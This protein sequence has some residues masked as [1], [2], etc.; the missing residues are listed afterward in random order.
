MLVRGADGRYAYRA[1]RDVARGEE[2]TWDYSATVTDYFLMPCLGCGPGCRGFACR[3]SFMREDERRRIEARHP[4]EW[5]LPHMAAELDAPFSAEGV[6]AR[7]L[8][9]GWDG[10]GSYFDF[11]ADNPRLDP[12]YR[13]LARASR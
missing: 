7:L 12:G 1:L 11:V 5:L 6:D 2:V 8:P 13:A 4:R 3:P 9:Y 10:E